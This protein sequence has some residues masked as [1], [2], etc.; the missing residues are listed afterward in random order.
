MIDPH[1]SNGLREKI[2]NYKE[3][4]VKYYEI[5]LKYAEKITQKSAK[6]IDSASKEYFIKSPTKVF[7]KSVSCSSLLS[8]KYS[9]P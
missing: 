7:I 6:I 9:I 4:I 1:V 3:D 5:D 8:K 2:V